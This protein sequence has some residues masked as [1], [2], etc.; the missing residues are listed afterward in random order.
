MCLRINIIYHRGHKCT[1][2][3]S[4]FPVLTYTAW[5]MT[6]ASRVNDA[7]L[8]RIERFKDSSTQ[9]YSIPYSV[10]LSTSQEV[11]SESGTP[12]MNYV[13]ICRPP[14][15]LLNDIGQVLTKPFL[16]EFNKIMGK[17]TWIHFYGSISPPS[18]PPVYTVGID[19]AEPYLG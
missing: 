7:Y 18:P 10:L 12:Q 14:A 8:S 9:T 4:P 17:E 13:S 19:I 15:H 1:Y 16:N 5:R 11:S 3:V 6:S 2:T